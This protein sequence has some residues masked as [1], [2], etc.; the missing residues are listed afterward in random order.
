MI[1]KYNK[2]SDIKNPRL[3]WSKVE[4]TDGCW[5]WKGQIAKLLPYGI[6]SR[7]PA[8]RVS[9]ML[10]HNQDWPH[11]LIARHQCHNHSCVN[12]DH[13]IP[14]THKENWEDSRKVYMKAMKEKDPSVHI[15]RAKK[16]RRK[17]QTPMGVFESVGATRSALRISWNT[18]NKLINDP[19]SGYK[20]ITNSGEE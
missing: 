9:W 5:L 12:P 20:Y 16:R 1:N 10:T 7:Y 19:D 3:F 4:K 8:H 11:N 15:E 2:L 14:G 18:L 13:I 17:V 6:Y